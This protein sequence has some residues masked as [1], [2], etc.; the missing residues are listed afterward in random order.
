MKT[1]SGQPPLRFRRRGR[2]RES[3]QA[4]VELVFI[5][6]LLLAMMLALFDLG[7]AFQAYMSVVHAAREGARLAMDCD[8]SDQEVKD[9][10]VASAAPLNPTVT[11][12]RGSCP[13][14]MSLMSAGSAASTVTVTYELNWVTP[15]VGIFWRSGSS[16]EMSSTMVSR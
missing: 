12:D 16:V 7:R 5:V 3:G 11:V 8:L 2:W 14:G 6:A 9:A 15:V 1:R 4:A 10:A 13:G